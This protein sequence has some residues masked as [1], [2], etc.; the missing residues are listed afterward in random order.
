MVQLGTYGMVSI[1]FAWHGKGQLGGEVMA[2]Q[3]LNVGCA[4]QI[5][6]RELCFPVGVRR[7]LTAHIQLARRL[8]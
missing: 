7:Y 3:R 4:L 6:A 2:P 8:S 1:Q 5:R